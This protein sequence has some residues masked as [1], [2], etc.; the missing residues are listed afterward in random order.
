MDESSC[1]TKFSTSPM[2]IGSFSLSYS[3]PCQSVNS[4]MSTAPVVSW[5]GPTPRLPVWCMNARTFCVGR[6]V[7]ETARGQWLGRPFG[8]Q[9][10]EPTVVRVHVGGRVLE[11]LSGHLC[12]RGAWT[13]HS[14][15]N[16]PIRQT[17]FQ[18]VLC[19]NASS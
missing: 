2:Q 10:K 4:S 15:E 12:V 6:P 7:P 16:A 17:L 19:V 9:R 5:M 11:V 3:W 13:T 14:R 8:P 1:D 18:V